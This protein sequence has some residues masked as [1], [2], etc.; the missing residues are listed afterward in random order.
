MDTTIS[1]SRF[2]WLDSLR[3]FA[4][5]SVAFYHIFELAQIHFINNIFVQKSSILSFFV[6]GFLDFGKIGVVVF[7][8]ISGFVIPQSLF[9]KSLKSFTFGRFFRLYPAYWFAI[10][11][12]VILL[13]IPNVS[14]LLVNIT[15]LQR[16]VG[17]ADLLGV[18]WTLQIELIFYGLCFILHYFN[19]L[20]EKRVIIGV[21]IGLIG[22]TMILAFIRYHFII[23]TPIALGLGLLVM[24]LG[25]MLRMFYNQMIFSLSEL[26][27]YNFIFI[28]ILLVVCVLAYSRDYGFHETWYK[29]FFSYLSGLFIFYL[30]YN[31]KFSNKIYVYL[32]IISYSVYLLHPIIL[33]LMKRLWCEAGNVSLAL[34]LL[35]YF[36]GVLVLG[37]ISYFVIERPMVKIGKKL[38]RLWL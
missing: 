9:N 26:L 36:V 27:K 32:G 14:D 21:F 10:F 16:F 22:I 4:A 31:F 33:G 20:F 37:S 34:S 24:I 1:P 35:I 3:G 12:S 7:F 17:K 23:K 38:G 30:F 13:N 28:F 15:M 5:L 2:E 19:I 29:Y 25:F 6:N 11:L 8:F 18:F